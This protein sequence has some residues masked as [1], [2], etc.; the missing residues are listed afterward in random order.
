MVDTGVAPRFSIEL[1][2]LS[3]ASVK[4]IPHRRLVPSSI[5]GSSK[6]KFL[7]KERTHMQR[8]ALVLS[9][10]TLAVACVLAPR[11]STAASFN[12]GKASTLIESLICRDPVLSRQDSKM[13]TLY[14]DVLRRSSPGDRQSVRDEQRAWIEERDRCEDKECLDLVY[15]KRIYDL[16]H[17]GE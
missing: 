12:C 7:K 15:S 2:R 9:Q 8:N 16:K 13:A 10:F 1:V 5:R 4:G 3:R 17:F 6:T 11:S 14:R